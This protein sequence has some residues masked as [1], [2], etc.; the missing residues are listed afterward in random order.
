[1]DLAFLLASR[2]GDFAGGGGGGW[3][4]GGEDQGVGD[5]LVE[6]FGGL[7]SD[8]DGVLNNGQ[9]LGEVPWFGSSGWGEMSS[10]VLDF[11]PLRFFFR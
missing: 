9:E 4:V 5:D 6:E 2:L 10:R 3:E 11:L 7:G 1:M 8:L